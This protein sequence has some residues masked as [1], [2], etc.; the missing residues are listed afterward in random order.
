MR[1]LVAFQATQLGADE[2]DTVSTE[3]SKP[4]AI[5][6]MLSALNSYWQKQVDED[7]EDR[8]SFRYRA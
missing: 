1:G 6:S 7:A 3:E 2:G 4:P 8:F 5:F